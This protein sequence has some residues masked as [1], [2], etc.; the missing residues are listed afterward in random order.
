MKMD[1][2]QDIDELT[3]KILE[4][5]KNE[6]VEDAKKNLEE[7]RRNLYNLKND[8]Q[9]SKVRAK[10]KNFHPETAVGWNFVG[11]NW[12]KVAT[13]KK[14]KGSG[15]MTWEYYSDDDMWAD[16]TEM[17]A[18]G[19]GTVGFGATAM[20]I[21]PP[22]GFI[23][24]MFQL[25]PDKAKTSLKEGL[26]KKT[27][28]PFDLIENF[29]PGY[30]KFVKD[31]HTKKKE[32]ITFKGADGKDHYEMDESTNSIKE[33]KIYGTK[34]EKDFYYENNA[35]K[36][37]LKDAEKKWNIAKLR[38]KKAMERENKKLNEEKIDEKVDKETKKIDEKINEEQKNFFENLKKNSYDFLKEKIENNEIELED[39]ESVLKHIKKSHKDLKNNKDYDEIFEDFKRSLS[40][41]DIDKISE[42]LKNKENEKK[43]K[44]QEQIKKQEENK[45][46]EQLEKKA[47]EEKEKKEKEN[48]D[49]FN[50]NFM[51]Q[52]EEKR[53]KEEEEK[54]KKMEEQNKGRGR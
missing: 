11:K 44:E 17:L 15:K 4:S 35:Y 51:E 10:E 48:T 31:A 47:K 26:A 33:K 41:K 7:C 1:K 36:E 43:D 39:K 27:G 16:I 6:T 22:L 21:C 54:K 24:M 28:I 40:K 52:L 34:A 14:D 8:Q 53:K 13:Y 19:Y 5:Y 46:K 42:E 3:N 9:P 45:K 30:R 38:F 49:I 29:D 20:L 25:M 32:K 50:K 2:N 37:K 12:G 23:L 18:G